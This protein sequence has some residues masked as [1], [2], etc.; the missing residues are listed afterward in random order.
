MRWEPKKGRWAGETCNGS[1]NKG[2]GWLKPAKIS[3]I[4]PKGCFDSVKKARNGEKG[5]KK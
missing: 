5:I 4:Y 1:Q 3:L 2:D